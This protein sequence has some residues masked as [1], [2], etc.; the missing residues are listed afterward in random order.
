MNPAG[1]GDGEMRGD[2]WKLLSC[3]LGSSIVLRTRTTPGCRV[4]E[5]FMMKMW[6]DQNCKTIAET[7][8]CNRDWEGDSRNW[9]ESSR[10]VHGGFPLTSKGLQWGLK[11]NF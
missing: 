4:M 11:D 9:I 8:M 7:M 2:G 5:I 10:G 1:K 3:F 6:H